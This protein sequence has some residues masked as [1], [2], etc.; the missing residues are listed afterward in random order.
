MQVE[1]FWNASPR[2]KQVHHREFGQG[3]IVT[4]HAWLGPC[5]ESHET[6]VKFS[7]P[8]IGQRVVPVS[9]LTFTNQPAS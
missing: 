4:G 5:E 8:L 3:I 6:L 2:G 1:E 9:E 7:D